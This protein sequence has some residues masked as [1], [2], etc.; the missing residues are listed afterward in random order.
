[1]KNIISKIK[2]ASFAIGASAIGA[3]IAIG[4]PSFAG[5]DGNEVKLNNC[6]AGIAKDKWQ[7]GPCIFS[8]G[9]GGSFAL[10][11][12]YPDDY[13]IEG[14]AYYVRVEVTSKGKGKAYY[15]EWKDTP[16]KSLGA[17]TR[18]QGNQ[19]ACWFGSKGVKIC[20]K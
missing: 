14:Y 9:T 2:T 6:V 20:A 1:M 8:R 17:V 10:Y 18:G 5:S 12:T 15:S 7:S 19:A 13:L 4:S 16:E 3:M 11:A